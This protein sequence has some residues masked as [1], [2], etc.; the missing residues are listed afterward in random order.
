MIDKGYVSSIPFPD[1]RQALAEGVV[2][3][4]GRLDVGT[5][6]HAYV[7]GIFPW[8]QEGYPMLWFCPDE[9]G[10][11]VFDEMKI[12]RSLQRSLKKNAGYR[13]SRN[14]AFRRVVESCRRQYRPGQLG[15]WILPEMVEAYARFRDAGFAHSFEVWKG[16]ELVGGMYGVFVEGVFSGESMFHTE[17][18]ASKRALI[19]AIESLKAEGVKW[20]DTQMVT[21]VVEKLGGR[22][23]PR[24]E[25]LALMREAQDDWLRLRRNPE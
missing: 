7:K 8:P 23:I 17:A 13:F 20:I 2:A 15:T 19:F 12:P 3:V 10:I 6:Y 21:D 4:G 1:P 24:H 11:L 9:R 22:L 14:E 16:S 25:Y 18:D 5:L